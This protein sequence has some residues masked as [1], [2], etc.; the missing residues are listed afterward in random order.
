MATGAAVVVFTALTTDAT[1]LATG[2]AAVLF[3]ALTTDATDLVAVLVAGAAAGDFGTAAVAAGGVAAATAAGAV[4]AADTTCEIAWV[5]EALARLGSAKT[6]SSKATA[7]IQPVF[8][9]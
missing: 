7:A 2:A 5:G 3:T 1:G 8:E 6:T 9:R 4:E